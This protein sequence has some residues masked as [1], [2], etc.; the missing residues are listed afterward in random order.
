MWEFFLHF[1][2]IVFSKNDKL[3]VFFFFR[4]TKKLLLPLM[5]HMLHHLC[6]GGLILGWTSKHLAF[7][8]FKL[9]PRL[10]GCYVA[11]VKGDEGVI[12][13][14]TKA[15]CW[16]DGGAN[17][18]WQMGLRLNQLALSGVTAGN[19]NTHSKLEKSFQTHHK[20]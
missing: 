18:I 10:V 14:V 3:T 17:S 8:N 5:C 12:R 11:E 9:E 2:H 16:H 6:T 7:S 4:E 15:A 19:I 1:F 20:Q 13:L